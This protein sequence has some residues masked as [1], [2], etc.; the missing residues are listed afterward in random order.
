M[1]I[2]Q[3]AENYCANWC[4]GN[5]CVG[6]EINLATG[7]QDRWRAEGSKCLLSEGKRCPVLRELRSPDGGMAL[8]E[9]E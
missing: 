9:S 2:V 5:L 1:K 3:L 4:R 7:L 8:E 6:T